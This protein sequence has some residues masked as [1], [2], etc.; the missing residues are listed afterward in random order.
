MAIAWRQRRKRL[1]AWQECELIYEDVPPAEIVPLDL[2]V[3]IHAEGPESHGPFT[4]RDT[5]SGSL[6]A[7]RGILP[8]TWGEELHEAR[9]Q[10]FLSSLFDDL[11]LGLR[12][13][14]R[15]PLSSAMIVATLTVGIGINAS[16]YSIIDATAIRPHVQ[17][18]PASFIDIIPE[19]QATRGPRI[20]SASEYAAY[21]QAR[22]L[23]QLVA[24]GSINAL[25][26]DTGANRVDMLGVSCNFFSLDGPVRPILGRPLVEGDCQGPEQSAVAVVSETAWRSYF[27]GNPNLIGQTIHLDEK[28]FTVAG[29]VP[30][31]TAN[32]VNQSVGIW[33]PY[34]SAPWLSAFREDDTLWLWLAGRLAPGVTAAQARLELILL[35]RQQDRLVPGRITTFATTNGSLIQQMELS[36]E[37]RSLMLTAFFLGT[38]NL[39]LFIACANVST[40]LLSRA[41]TRRREISI[42]LQLGAPR[43]RLARMLLTES[44]LLAA[45]A[46]AVSVWLVGF[47]PAP[48]AR[49]IFTVAP[50]FPMAPD[51][52][53]FAYIAG[54]VLITGILAGLTPAFESMGTASRATSRRVLGGLVSLQVALSMVLLVTS[55]LLGLAENRSLRADPGY[56]PDRIVMAQLRFPKGTAVDAAQLRLRAIA[57]RLQSLPGVRSTAITDDTPLFGPQTVELRPPL[58]KD[59]VQPV[60]IFPASP[61]F[62]ETMGIPLVRGRE[63]QSSDGAAVIVSETLA[64]AFW[65]RRDPLGQTLDLPTGPALVVGIAKDVSPTRFGGSDN[66]ALYRLRDS[67][68]LRNVISVRFDKGARQGPAAVR[69]AVREIE[70]GLTVAPILLQAEIERITADLWNFVALILILGLV[71]VALSTSGI[72]GTVSLAV[73]QGIRDLGIRLALG[74]RKMDI[75]IEVLVSGGRPVLHGLIAGLWLSVATAATL[76]KILGNLPLR[77]DASDPLLYA[78]AALVLLAAAVA[79]MAAP[80]RRGAQSDPAAVRRCA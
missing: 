38:F 63:F 35:A 58:R 25:L 24:Y 49:A 15:N 74:A 60:D 75:F 34:T 47:V 76:R 37:G 6:S 43:L 41:V 39:V 54:A 20:V 51:W 64:N 62:F 32:W 27:G 68:T 12:L 66:P 45:L 13:I 53:T 59:A 28:P 67:N 7:S 3:Y 65:R 4:D 77:I 36:A 8:G 26:G 31:N 78:G 1:A 9:T 55:G 17:R 79:A 69:A 19:S 11:R 52:S 72:Y 50:D 30:D 73:N 80:A 33:I 2:G 10:P 42:R 18:D 56:L 70:P 40:L 44:L 5:F 71:G 57:E 21:R 14:R 48:L 29:I 22:G 61:R 46:G 23:R 16:V